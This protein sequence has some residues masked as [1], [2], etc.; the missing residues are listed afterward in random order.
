MSVELLNLQPLAAADCVAPTDLLI[1]VAG[2]V[3]VEA[4]DCDAAVENQPAELPLLAHYALLRQV[5]FAQLL[6]A[7]CVPLLLENGMLL[8]EDGTLAAA[9]AVES[10]MVKLLGIA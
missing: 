10:A 8:L 1:V 4:V 3:V 9:G 6:L 2:F 5:D 7:D